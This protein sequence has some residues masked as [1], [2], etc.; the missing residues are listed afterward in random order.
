MEIRRELIKIGAK[1]IAPCTHEEECKLPKDDWCHSSCR[2]ARTKIHKQLKDGV[3]PYED[4]KFS[5]MAFSKTPY[6]KAEIRVLRHPK[7]EPGK[8]TLNICTKDDIKKIIVTKKDKQSFKLARKI[9]CGDKCL[10]NEIDT[11]SYNH[12]PG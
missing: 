3:V 5:Y 11:G 10:Y 4:E 12:I 6:K 1:V 7:I 9:K 8:I 2:I